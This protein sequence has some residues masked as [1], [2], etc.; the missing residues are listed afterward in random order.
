MAGVG[1]VPTSENITSRHKTTCHS[2]FR[3]IIARAVG[4]FCRPANEIY[5][6]NIVRTGYTDRQPEKHSASANTWKPNVS[7]SLPSRYLGIT[8]F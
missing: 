6:T 1:L 7:L 4:L 2:A 5:G 3:G 8:L